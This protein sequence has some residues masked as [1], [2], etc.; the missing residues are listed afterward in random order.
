MHPDTRSLNPASPTALRRRLRAARAALAPEL[1]AAA[2]T[3]LLVHARQ[4]RVLRRARRVAVHHAVGGE[5][6]PALVVDW[7]AS[8]AV[9][10]YWPRLESRP[11]RMRFVHARPDGLTQ[12]NR[13]GIP[14]P[15]AHAPHL[16]PRYL[17]LVLLP[18]VGFDAH[19]TRL[20]SGA[21]YYD[22]AFAFRTSRRHWRAPLLVGVAYAAQEVPTLVR[23]AWDVPLDAVLTEQG[24]RWFRRPDGGL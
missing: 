9:D 6:D 18:L 4:Q 1:R 13:H 19:G 12:L 17:D 10:L 21:G 23:A 7:L 8:R 2:H 5:L 20:G 11:G 14:E 16:D 22:R 15:D 24:M 3:A